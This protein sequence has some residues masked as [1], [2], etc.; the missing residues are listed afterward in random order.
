VKNPRITGR[1]RNLGQLIAYYIITIN[2]YGGCPFVNNHHAKDRLYS[3]RYSMYNNIY[4]LARCRLP[5]AKDYALELVAAN[6]FT[7]SYNVL[8]YFQ[9][10]IGVAP[11]DNIHAVCKE[12]MRY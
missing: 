12:T 11:S 2:L 6:L 7:C 1:H 3:I 10:K 8:E 5:R 9:S 4:N